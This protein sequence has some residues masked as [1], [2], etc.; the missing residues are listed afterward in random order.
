MGGIFSCRKGKAKKAILGAS[1]ETLQQEMA[2][3]GF[4][5]K[6]VYEYEVSA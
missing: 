6:T 5:D 4:K 1:S 2:A 3:A